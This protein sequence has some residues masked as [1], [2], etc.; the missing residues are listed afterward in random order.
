MIKKML[1]PLV[2]LFFA[3]AQANDHI[4]YVAYNDAAEPVHTYIDDYSLIQGNRPKEDLELSTG[5]YAICEAN[6][7]RFLIIVPDNVTA[8]LILCDGASYTGGIHI[9]EKAELIIYGQENGTGTI[10]AV[11]RIVGGVN[12]NSYVYNAPI[13]G[14]PN[15]KM[16]SLQIHGGIINATASG[17]SHCAGIGGGSRMISPENDRGGNV[18][19]YNGTVTAQG[20]KY[21][22]GIG[23]GKYGDGGTLTVYDGTVTA[24]GGDF[25]AGIG[26]GQDGNGANVTIY[27]GSVSAYGG[28]DA[29]GIGSGEQQNGLKKGGK[30]IVHGG[31]VFADGTGWGAGIGGGEDSDGA[32]VE[33]YGGTVEA[34]AGADAADK[35]GSAI[36]SEDGDG[37]YGSLKIDGDVRVYAGNNPGSTSAFT[38]DV[39]VPACRWRPYARIEPCLSHENTYS[40]NE[41][42]HTF[43]CKWC[44][45]SLTE[46]HHEG[47]D[48]L[49]TVCGYRLGDGWWNV[50]IADAAGTTPNGAYTTWT[51]SVTKGQNYTLPEPTA[52]P[53]SFE[54]VGWYV[55]TIEDLVDGG[56]SLLPSIVNPVLHAPGATLNV[57]ENINIVAVYIQTQF[58]AITIATDRSSATIAGTYSGEDAVDIPSDITVQ[59]VTLNRT[60]VKDQF[61]T[62]VLPFSIELNNRVDGAEFYGLINMDYTDGKWTASASPVSGSL[63]ANTPYLVK[64]SAA[65]ITFVGPV[66]LNTSGSHKTAQGE[67]EFQGTYQYIVFGDVKADN[68]QNT[69]YGFAANTQDGYTAGQ[70]AKAGDN[71]FIYPMRA[72][73]VHVGANSNPK[74][75]G[76]LGNIGTLPESI[77][78]KIMDEQG[79]VTETV[80]LDTHTGVI[81]ND[82]WFDLQGRAL[83]GK[84]AIK[85]RYL[86]NGKVEAVR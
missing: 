61:S 9:S 80:I 66:T 71:A 85:G 35:N 46:D 28:D 31:Y 33:I 21:G 20:D 15:S 10:N 48:G 7:Q 60:F 79:N 83:K 19:I 64:P 11:D 6:V 86:H 32:V 43:T 51:A 84:P 78:V 56:Y 23:G 69:Y 76:G 16:G 25:A 73:L 58:G 67:W 42:Q 13:G 53:T 82:R 5:Y 54:F 59:S 50:L 40:F 52:T 2:L 65:S 68:P 45:H 70:F 41:T 27:G 4:P 22:A 34:W 75:A 17:G 39:R 81:R 49:C 72:Y 62:V 29:A 26:G 77:D 37:H 47:Q 38:S 44:G 3:F 24:R 36:G 8:F 30:L 63:T 18:T 12:S 1:F 14:R 74:D 57:N 55:G